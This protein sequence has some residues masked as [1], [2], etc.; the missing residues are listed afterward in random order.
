MLLDQLK[1]FGKVC[2]LCGQDLCIV[3]S[4]RTELDNSYI[5]TLENYEYPL[6]FERKVPFG[7]QERVIINEG[8]SASLAPNII[9]MCIQSVCNYDHYNVVFGNLWQPQI[10]LGTSNPQE[11]VYI[12]RYQIRNWMFKTAVSVRSNTG[13]YKRILLI[14]KQPLDF[15]H[16]QDKNKFE[17][18]LHKLLLLK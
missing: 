8:D 11:S 13:L 2:P 3:A 1:S 9:R 4:L 6:I 10:A 15:W 14:P 18:K 7:G 5:Y 16:I 17:G 12:D